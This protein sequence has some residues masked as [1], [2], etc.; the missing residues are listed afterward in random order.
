MLFILTLYPSSRLL[1]LV[2]IMILLGC[3]SFFVCVFRLNFPFYVPLSRLLCC[4]LVA[5]LCLTLAT[6]WTV[7]CQAPLSTDFLGKNSG[8]LSF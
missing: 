3:S 8:A 5:K 1:D 4:D 2:A 6:L 7:A